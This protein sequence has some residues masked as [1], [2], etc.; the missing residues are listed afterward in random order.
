MNASNGTRRAL[1]A[2]LTV[3]VAVARA[4]QLD[5][6]SPTPE[7]RLRTVEYRADSVIGLTAFVGYHIHLEFA[8]D[9]RFVTLAAGDTAA[10][11]V[12]AEGNH[13]M[14]KPKQANAG[15]NLTLLTNRRAYFIDYRALARAPRPDEAVYS[16]TFRYPSDVTTTSPVSGARPPIAEAVT[17]PAAV[18]ADYWY[19]GHPALRPSAADDDGIQVRL[20]FPA[21]TE[22]PAIY[23][24][25]EDGT[26]SLVN[27]HVEDDTV[28][29]HRLAERLVLRRGRLVG[30]VTNHSFPGATRR[31][32]SGTL[33]DSVE[34]RTRE[35]ER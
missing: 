24:A 21:R 7:P 25:A 23:S 27:S 17:L 5:S 26:E 6:N 29:V 4:D 15:T 3:A 11:D 33:R 19:C 14:L 28:I 10:I 2:L 8:P 32:S 16:V 20:R 18:N 9:E 22:L 12:G 1:G 34:R 30:C 35:I 31:A 13:L